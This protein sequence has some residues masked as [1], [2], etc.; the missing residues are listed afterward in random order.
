MDIIILVLLPFFVKEI[1]DF[2][3]Q[4]SVWDVVFLR[5]QI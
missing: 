5:G 2:G 3:F 1:A 4:I